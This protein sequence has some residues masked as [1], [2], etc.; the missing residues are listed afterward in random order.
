[1]AEPISREKRVHSGPD[2]GERNG[3]EDMTLRQ[4]LLESAIETFAEAGY[5]GAEVRSIAEGAGTSVQEFYE[6]FE[7]KESCALAAYDSVANG[8]VEGVRRACHENAETR[9]PDKVR[10]GLTALLGTIADEPTAAR[11]AIIEVPAAGPAAHAR[12]REA[13]ADFAPML[14]A[15]RQYA[16]LADQLP[17][18]VEL[19][20]IGSVEAIVFE[21]VSAGD[22]AKLRQMLPE[23][24]F[25]V[26]VPYLGPE[27][28]ASEM[29]GAASPAN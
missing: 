12:Y 14:E 26:L 18:H 27:Q 7:N 2:A 4:R 15:G 13:I 6:E 1:M 25:T 24:L 20:A 3:S 5:E 19:M 16:D 22:T 28:A 29:H 23:I 17:E 9:W 21:A 8:L 11:M 10:R